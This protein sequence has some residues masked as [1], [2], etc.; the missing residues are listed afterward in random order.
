M[1]KLAVVLGAVL[2]LLL[3]GGGSFYGGMVFERSRQT[4]LQAQF[5]AG[6]GFSEGGQIPL[7]GIPSEGFGQ[8]TGPNEPGGQGVIGRGANGTIESL[9][10]DTLQLSTGQ[11]VTTV[12]LTDQTVISRFVTGER[13]DL[14]PG[15]RILV[16]GERDDSGKI[17]ATSIQILSDAP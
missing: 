3:V 6:R 1:R 16:V 8:F 10:G 5:F 11:D 4:N 15:E 2:V 14:Q 7:G 13:S 17:T 9:E 12:L